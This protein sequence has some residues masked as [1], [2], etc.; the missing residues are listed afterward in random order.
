MSRYALLHA[1]TGWSI[2]LWRCE[3]SEPGSHPPERTAEH[4]VVFPTH[5]T[6]GR[7]IDGV[8]EVLDAT[9]VVYFNPGE[10]YAVDHPRGGGDRCTVLSLEAALVEALAATDRG[11]REAAAHGPRFARTSRPSHGR[12]HMA[13]RRLV[14]RLERGDADPVALEQTVFDLVRAALPAGGRPPGDRRGA[15]AERSHA[16]AVARALDKIHGEFRS[17]LTVTEI[18][19]AA[20]YSPFHLGRVFR[21]RTG[22]TLHRYINRLRLREALEEVVDGGRSIGAIALH[23]G[24]SS[25]SHFSEAFRSEFGTSPRAAVR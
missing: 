9:R 2:G 14:L 16:R 11:L 12:L 24:F 4:Q 20:A 23:Y 1:G 25:H 3:A 19:G 13:Q 18:A 6:Y 7:T 5:G 10:W 17:P 21:A 8:R 22:L 15:R